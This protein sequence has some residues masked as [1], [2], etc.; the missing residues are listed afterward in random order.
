MAKLTERIAFVGAG[1]MATALAQGMVKAGL[2]DASA[3]SASDVSPESREAFLEAVPGST[4]VA[5]NSEVIQDSQVM[6]LAVK[7][8]HMAEVLENLGALHP[9]QTLV[10]SI[11]AGVTLHKLSERL[12]AGTPASFG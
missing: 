11:A 4:V 12:P 8:Q 5:E 10:V 9:D 1:K 2:V 3:I 7:P 6:V